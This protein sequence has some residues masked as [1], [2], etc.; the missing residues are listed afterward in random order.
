MVEY[1]VLKKEPEKIFFKTS[2]CSQV[3]RSITLPRTTD[4]PK[5]KPK[6]LNSLKNKKVVLSKEKFEDLVSLCSDKLQSYEMRN[7]FCFIRIY[8]IL[9]E[10]HLKRLHRALA[11]NVA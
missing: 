3:Y 8:P 7:M 1:L 2:H 4:E 6:L 5:T 9:K 11:Q 10:T